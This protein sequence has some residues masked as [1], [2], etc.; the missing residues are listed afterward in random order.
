MV[1][2]GKRRG[3]TN[4]KIGQEWQVLQ[5]L[6][7]DRPRPLQKKSL[8][9]SRLALGKEES[10]QDVKHLCASDQQE[11]PSQDALLSPFASPSFGQ[12]QRTAISLTVGESGVELP[13]QIVACPASPCGIGLQC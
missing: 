3:N 2:S 13:F 9:T 12:G 8:S 6:E 11:K 10:I 7:K 5:E 4:A 1:V